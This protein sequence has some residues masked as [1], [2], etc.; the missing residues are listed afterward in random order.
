ML[1]EFIPQ[2][3]AIWKSRW[4]FVGAQVTFDLPSSQANAGCS[5]TEEKKILTRSFTKKILSGN[6]KRCCRKKLSALC[7]RGPLSAPKR[8]RKFQTTW[9]SP[10]RIAAFF[11]FFLLVV[12]PK[13]PTSTTQSA[14]QY[15]IIGF[16][17]P[18]LFIA[19]LSQPSSSHNRTAG[20]EEG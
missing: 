1:Q 16:V 3:P 18:S 2:N 8:D 7:N 6:R 17:L 15:G 11:F 10:P 13:P 9:R 19:P 4:Q 14:H 12:L 5:I 20:G